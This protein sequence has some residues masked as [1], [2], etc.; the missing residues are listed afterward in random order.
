MLLDTHWQAGLHG[1]SLNREHCR[2]YG[3]RDKRIRNI[4]GKRA[5]FDQVN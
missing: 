2:L 5:R 3:G 4:W 1:A